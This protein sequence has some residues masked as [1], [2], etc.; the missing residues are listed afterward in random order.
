VAVSEYAVEVAPATADQ[1]APPSLET[2]H[3][4]LGAGLP[5]AEAVNVARAPATTL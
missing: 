5:E 2:C 4:T 3:C 1:L